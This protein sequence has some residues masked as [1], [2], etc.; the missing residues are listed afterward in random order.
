[1]NKFGHLSRESR[2]RRSRRALAMMKVQ[3]ILAVSS[4]VI[5]KLYVH[6]DSTFAPV[7]LATVSKEPFYYIC[8][9]PVS[10]QI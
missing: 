5:D 8:F 4:A 7:D 10:A 1:M 2:E 3:F 9:C 6:P